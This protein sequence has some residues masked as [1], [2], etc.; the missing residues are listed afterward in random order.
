MPGKVT[1]S[2]VVTDQSLQ[3]QEDVIVMIIDGSHEFPDLAAVT[4]EKGQFQLPG[5]ETP[6]DYTLQFKKDEKTQT[7][8]IYVDK[9]P[10]ELQVIF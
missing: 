7:K 2:G 3:P 8:K 5:L 10:Q 1:I 9:Q 4:N 6:G